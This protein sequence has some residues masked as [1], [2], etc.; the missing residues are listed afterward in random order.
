MLALILMEQLTKLGSYPLL[1]S[2]P[3]MARSGTASSV[4]IVVLQF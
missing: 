2:A 3:A 4:D 1:K